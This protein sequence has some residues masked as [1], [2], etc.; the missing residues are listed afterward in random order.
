[1]LEKLV[2]RIDALGKELEQSAGRHNA[3]LGA[4][5]ELKALYNDAVAV[6][7][8]VEAIDPALTPEISAAEGVVNAVEGTV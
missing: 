3:L 8:V 5:Q 2:A 6:A 4:M 7:P 1:M